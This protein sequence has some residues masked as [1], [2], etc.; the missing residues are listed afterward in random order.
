MHRDTKPTMKISIGLFTQSSIEHPHLLA[1]TKWLQNK[2][3]R[4]LYSAINF[5]NWTTKK[6][7]TK[8]KLEKA[9][10]ILTAA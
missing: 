10:L 9:Y 8:S 6:W 4:K 3:S 5:Y 2:F 7:T 1:A